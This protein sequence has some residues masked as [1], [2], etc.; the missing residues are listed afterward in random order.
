ML[1]LEKL[2]T[3]GLMM[4]KTI[5]S[6][7]DALKYYVIKSSEQS[8]GMMIRKTKSFVTILWVVFREL[9]KIERSFMMMRK[10]K[11]CLGRKG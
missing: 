11:G 3:K 8:R 6:L 7:H 5:E 9:E 2:E 4:K 1:K 10:S